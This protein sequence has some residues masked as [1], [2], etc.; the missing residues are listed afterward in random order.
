MRD[1]EN[2]ID[3]VLTPSPR[4][5]T[6][7]ATLAAALPVAGLLL[8]VG[9]E[10]MEAGEAGEPIDVQT[11]ALQNTGRTPDQQKCDDKLQACYV[12]CSV[13]YPESGGGLND[14]LREGCF[15]A[16]DAAHNLC[17]PA[18]TVS[19]AGGVLQPGAA[20][21]AATAPTASAAVKSC[22]PT[23]EGGLWCCVRI[24]TPPYLKCTYTPPPDTIWTF[25]QTAT[26][27]R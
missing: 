9:C 11:S 2:T 25:T 16:C 12:D 8:I 7:R 20:L 6:R 10:G 23:T 26:R 14:D 21:D 4:R 27:A 15:D 5:R 18:L 19:T 1:S 17:A 22:T 3:R 24:S 13:R